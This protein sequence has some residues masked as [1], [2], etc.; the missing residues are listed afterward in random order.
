[1]CNCRPVAWNKCFSWTHRHCDC[2]A[3]V[4]IPAIQ[5]PMT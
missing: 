5:Y 4:L 3:S 2:C 1:L